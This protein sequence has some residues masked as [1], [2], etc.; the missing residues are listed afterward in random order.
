[1]ITILSDE[2][3]TQIGPQLQQAF[4]AAGQQADLVPLVDTQVKPCVNCGGCT[5]RTYGKCVTRDDGDWVYPKIV[6]AQALLVVTPIVFGGY[7]LRAKRVL[8]KFGLFMDRHYYL[9]NGELTKGGQPGRPFR[10]FPVGLREGCSQEETEAFRRLAQETI[11]IIQGR[12]RA[13][14]TDDELPPQEAQA[15]V[16]EVLSA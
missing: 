5:Y 3:R 14:L 16:R 1:M 6:R 12:G 7:S 9:V 4:Q 11:G 10:F 13:L 2:E 8:D 15:I